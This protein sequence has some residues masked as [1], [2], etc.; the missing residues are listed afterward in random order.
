MDSLWDR[1]T[2]AGGKAWHEK[3]KGEGESD[4]KFLPRTLGGFAL[5]CQTETEH[6]GMVE[7]KRPANC[8]AGRRDSG[9][10]G[11]REGAGCEENWG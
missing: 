8:S 1:V 2:Q 9:V 11:N 10:K 5:R 7:K 3:G 4:T 6:K